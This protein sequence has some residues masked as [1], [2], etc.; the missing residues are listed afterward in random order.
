MGLLEV[1]TYT[2]TTDASGNASTST[3]DQ[4]RTAH[5]NGFIETVEVVYEDGVPSTCN[6]VIT[7][8]TPSDTILSLTE[9][10]T[11]GVWRP[12]DLVHTNDGV[13]QVASVGLERFAVAGPLTITV[14]G[15]GD[16]KMIKVRVIYQRRF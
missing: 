1:K 7:S 9:N 14:S 13:Q 6:L 16:T 10:N 12:R 15:G 5:I 2:L 8:N 11:S 3:P 4:S